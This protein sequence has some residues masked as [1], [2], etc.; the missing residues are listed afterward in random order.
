MI[1]SGPLG[2]GK[3]RY[4][5]VWSGQRVLFLAAIEQIDYVGFSDSIVPGFIL[6][7][8]RPRALGCVH[9][10]IGVCQQG[11][12][13]RPIGGKAGDAYAGVQLKLTVRQTEGFRD[14]GPQRIGHQLC[15]V[16]IAATGEQHDK[17]VAA[18]AGQHV[19]SS[20]ALPQAHGH[21]A[22]Q[23]VARVMAAA[24]VYELETIEIQVEQGYRLVGLGGALDGGLQFH[25][26]ALSI[27]QSGQRVVVGA[28]FQFALETP[29]VGYVAANTD[30]H[31]MLGQPAR[32]PLYVHIVAVLV[33][34]PIAK[35]KLQFACHDPI[36]LLGGGG[37]IIGMHQVKNLL[38]EHFFRCVPKDPLEACIDEQE[39]PSG[40]HHADGIK[41]QVE[42]VDKRG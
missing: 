39:A 2:V 11:V 1:R 10:P 8:Q 37:T 42:H 17:L 13:V 16:G 5:L 28:V 36:S 9:G 31:A 12:C 22:Q 33:D 20:N 26:Q 40:I 24:V 30:A 35:M 21:F 32:R 15:G 3:A 4:G 19:A 18:D 6:R 7:M 23:M 25:P 29:Q 41:H 27:C 14:A 34:V 38:A